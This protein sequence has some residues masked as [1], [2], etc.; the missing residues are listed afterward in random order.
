MNIGARCSKH[1]LKARGTIAMRLSCDMSRKHLTTLAGKLTRTS[2]MNSWSPKKESAPGP[3]GIPCSLCRCAGG[4]VS[5][6]LYNAYKHVLEDAVIPALFAKSRTV[7]VPKSSVVDI[8]GRTIRSPE[9]L[10]PLTLCNCDCKESHRGDLPRPSMVHHEVFSSLSEVHH[11]QAYDRQHF[12]DR[13]YCLGTCCV[14][15]T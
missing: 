12:R 7:F 1:A 4:L 9:A 3:D 15:P 6:F 8:N 13:D 14:R 5:R 2:S 11:F 10:R